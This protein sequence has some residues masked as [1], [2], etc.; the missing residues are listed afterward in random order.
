M[1]G[2]QVYVSRVVGKEISVVK[3]KR[4]INISQK[5]INFHSSMTAEELVGV[6]DFDVSETVYNVSDP[7]KLVAT[8][9]L[10]HV[11]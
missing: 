8:M 7:T 3:I 11:L 6:I 2:K 9:N 1:W 10:R 5:H 4:L